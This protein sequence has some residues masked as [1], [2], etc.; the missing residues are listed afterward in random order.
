[1]AP[2]QEI[3]HFDGPGKAINREWKWMV[4][5]FK[6][7]TNHL[8]SNAVLETFSSLPRTPYPKF[9]NNPLDRVLLRLILIQ[10]F[11]QKTEI[12]GKYKKNF[13]TP[14][15]NWLQAIQIGSLNTI[16]YDKF[17]L[18]IP[19]SF[20]ENQFLIGRDGYKK[21]LSQQM[22]CPRKPVYD[23]TSWVFLLA[24][25]DI[26]WHIIGILF[27]KM[28]FLLHEIQMS[29][30]QLSSTIQSPGWLLILRHKIQRRRQERF[31]LVLLKS[32]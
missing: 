2:K 6:K 32:S 12:W 18:N 17:G 13:W 29:D 28:L 19:T 16:S 3:Y 24:K 1:M 23:W 15:S 25:F 22:F 11:P 30:K 5:K 21:L 14:L 7:K 31:Y 20:W 27:H 9:L 10:E 26:F 4:T 8:S